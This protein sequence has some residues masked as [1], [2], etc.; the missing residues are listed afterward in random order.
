MNFHYSEGRGE[1]WF[2]LGGNIDGNP[3]DGIVYLYSDWNLPPVDSIE[4]DADGYVY[5]TE[6]IDFSNGLQVSVVS[7]AGVEHQ[8]SG[9]IVNGQ[10]NLCHGV[11][12]TKISF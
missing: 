10:C 5:T 4:I 8:M 6:D 7:G 12:T 11:T 2:T 9:K 1:G 3:G